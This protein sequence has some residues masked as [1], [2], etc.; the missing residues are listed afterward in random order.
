MTPSMSTPVQPGDFVVVPMAPPGGLAIE[1][2]E[3]LQEFVQRHRLSALQKYEHAEVYVGSPDAAGP[4]GYTCSTYPNRMGRRPLPCLPE[5]LTGALWSSGIV[6]LTTSQRDGIVAWCE[7]RPK[8]PYSSLD[9]VALTAHTLGLD[10]A[11]LQAYI[12]EQGHQI[13]SQYVDAAYM[14]N[15]VHLFTDDRWEGFVTPLDLALQLEAKGVLP[16]P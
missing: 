9:Y 14:S 7:A 1:A 15:G 8:V 13:C 2:A 10:T 4:Y 12:K 6:D 16:R 3:A 11:W 5:K